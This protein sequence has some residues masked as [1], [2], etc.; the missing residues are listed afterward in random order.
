MNQRDM[1][2][3]EAEHG[4]L[5]AL[6]HK[7]ELCEQIGAYLSATH[8][9]DADAA[10]LYNLIL[11]THARGVRPDSVTL[12]DVCHTLP[13]GE[14]TI[15]VASNIMHNVQSVANAMSYAKTVYERAQ[16]RRLYQVGVE[17]TQLAQTRGAI[18]SQVAEAQQALFDMNVVED[19][20]D[21]VTY[22]DM[23][24]GVI[25]QVDHRYNGQVEIGLQFGLPD[26]DSILQ[27]L[28][29]ANLIIIAGKPGTGKTVLATTLA[30]KIAIHDG[31]SA[32]V[33]SLEMPKEELTS[34]SLCAIGGIDKS[35]FDTG[36][37]SDEDWPRLTS[38]T[39]LLN[40]A[41]VRICDKPALTLSRICNIARFQHR[42]NPL[43]LIVIDYLTLIRSDKEDRFGTR[44]QEVGA[45]SRGLKAL[46][47]E[48]R[49]PVVVLA[50]LN[51]AADS[52][53]SA[54]SKPRMSDLRD[55]GEIEQDA[56]VVILGHRADDAAGRD[57]IT[58][59][60][61]AKVRH[62]RPGYCLLQFQGKHQRF[63]SVAKQD[64]FAYE[65]NARK[66]KSAMDDFTPGNF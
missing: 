11:S 65:R 35:L 13:S 15:V 44:S 25:D 57:G 43:N 9:G 2:A 40:S 55:S 20:P 45:F 60:D 66:S 39:N 22:H 16:A 56:D 51:R 52:R 33:F 62:A 42:A 21:V 17:I 41:D 24:P 27:G 12:A 7:P 64:A 8:F 61:V 28:R 1:Y 26:L 5:G 46:A 36:K 49:I 19:T 18:P 3:P 14:P 63:V 47:K 54:D 10:M 48:L 4:V 38:A 34:R 50:Q 29:P 32:L 30:D 37:L 59:W 6:M 58:T 31:K 53:S 23:L